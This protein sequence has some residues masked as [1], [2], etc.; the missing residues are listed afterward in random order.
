MGPWNLLLIRSSS[1]IRPADPAFA[2]MPMI[3]TLRTHHGADG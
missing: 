3:T 1:T 2:D